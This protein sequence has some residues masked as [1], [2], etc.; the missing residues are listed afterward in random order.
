MAKIVGQNVIPA[1]TMIS[2]L[3]NV[4]VDL[5][6]LPQINVSGQAAIMAT[7]LLAKAQPDNIFFDDNGN[8]FIII[9]GIRYSLSGVEYF[10]DTN[11][12][13]WVDVYDRGEEQNHLK[14]DTGSKRYDLKLAAV[15]WGFSSIPFK[16]SSITEVKRQI[17]STFAGDFAANEETDGSND[18]VGVNMPVICFQLKHKPENAVKLSDIDLDSATSKMIA[19]GLSIQA[20]QEIE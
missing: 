9:E 5:N 12:E 17:I 6:K 8:P 20:S 2:Q 19:A 7:G 10:I 11:G 16:I 1:I 15:G 3:L 14:N 4:G 13:I 18:I